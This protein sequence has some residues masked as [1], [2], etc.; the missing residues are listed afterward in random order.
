MARAVAWA[1]LLVATAAAAFWFLVPRETVAV[2]A[3]VAPEALGDLDR[4]FADA[5]A[6]FDD[7]VPGTEKR[8]LWAG[9]PGAR[10]DL[11]ILYVHG[12]SATSEEI[13]PVPDRVAGA[14]GANLVFTRLQGHGRGG[15]AMAEAS[16]AGWMSDL[17]EGLAA[18]RAA[19][20]RVVVIATST[21]AT[22][23][24]L[25]LGRPEL[26]EGVAG[27]VLVSPNYA[28]HGRFAG[29][30]T[31]P[32]ARIWLPWLL[33]PTRGFEPRNEAH[34]RYWTQSY[35]VEAL[36]PMAALVAHVR[37]LDPGGIGVP[38]LFWFSDDDQVVRAD[39]ARAVAA[40]WGG[41]VRLHPVSPGPTDD[42]AA[43]V[44]AGDI[45]SPGL[46]DAAETA[47]TAWIRALPEG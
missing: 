34:A 19:G 2:A 20:D 9:A 13:R 10:T 6:R 4:H 17:A 32:A 23:V 27:V 38:A 46:T 26:A 37:R 47:I 14:L 33:G 28:L 1:L 41:A 40:R 21:G 42:P 31:W 25:A 11:A 18:A 5:E 45:L 12:F 3:P 43:H 16:V 8:V 36:L 24:T 22:L 7:I 29:L 35:P 30:L 44:L 39:A 15:A